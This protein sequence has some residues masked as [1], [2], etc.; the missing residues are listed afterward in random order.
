LHPVEPGFRRVRARRSPA[1]ARADQT[2]IESGSGILAVPISVPLP[3]LVL[4]P[5]VLVLEVDELSRL[6]VTPDVWETSCGGE[7]GLAT[8]NE[9]LRMPPFA[10][11]A[12]P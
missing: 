5:V 4:V 2:K 9:K 11:D 8:S 3:V 10:N 12:N 7:F 6:I 1:P